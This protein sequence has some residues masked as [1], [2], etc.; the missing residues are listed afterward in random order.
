MTTSTLHTRTPVAPNAPVQG[1]FYNLGFVLPLM[2]S[3]LPFFTIGY[4][5]KGGAWYVPFAAA[6][7]LYFAFA[8]L[9]LVMPEGLGVVKAQDELAMTRSPWFSALL[10]VQLPLQVA[11]IGY[12]LWAAAQLNW[13]QAAAAAYAVGL[14]TG[15]IGITYAHELGHRKQKFSKLLGH[16]LMACCGYGQFM[17]E[18]Y[19][20]HHLRVATDLDPATSR[21]GEWI[22]AFW[23]RTIV[24]Q[25][26]SAW[27]LE[28]DRLGT[29]WSWRNLMLWHTAWFVTAPILFTL[30]LGPVAGL[31]WLIQALMGVFMLESVNYIEH[32]GLRRK[33]DGNTA[34]GFERVE[35]NHSWNTYAQPTN[36][37]LVHLQ[38]HSDHH[39]YQG[40][41]FQLLRPAEAAPKLPTGYSGCI[42]LAT[43]CPPLWIRVMGKKLDGLAAAEAA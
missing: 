3:C 42:L 7:G 16:G 23:V 22:Q 5:L 14:V 15:S 27:Q 34:I 19:R 31:F 18:H 28:I 12:G 38:R 1:R 20:G 10:Y 11:L 29:A 43:L 9:E 4:V 2:F 26:K 33:P 13:L 35:Q 41:P 30:W 8:A 36:W 25:F 39:T 32:Y 17:I 40:R 6:V 21:R 37:L 24:G